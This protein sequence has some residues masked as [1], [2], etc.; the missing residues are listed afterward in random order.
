MEKLKRMTDVYDSI[1]ALRDFVN[2]TTDFRYRQMN[3]LDCGFRLC[4]AMDVLEDTDM[5]THGY[6]H[7]DLGRDNLTELYLCLYGLFQAMVVQQD[8]VASAYESLLKTKFDMG[9]DGPLKPVWDIRQTRISAFGHPTDREIRSK[10]KGK[11]NRYCQVVQATMGKGSFQLHIANPHAE[12]RED[13]DEFRDIDTLDMVKRQQEFTVDKLDRLVEKLKEEHEAFRQKFADKPLSEA[14]GKNL[15]YHLGKVC[16]CVDEGIEDPGKW[17]LGL[18]NLDMVS[19]ALENLESVLKERELGLDTYP[20]IEYLYKEL[21][22]P[23]GQLRVLFS[24]QVSGEELDR[25]IQDCGVFAWFVYVK[26]A[27]EKE[28]LMEL[29]RGIDQNWETGVM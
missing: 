13:K 22:H 24:Q 27:G 18:A 23:L 21:E 19:K 26:I 11:E 8:A 3:D 29:V 9:P 4:S 10:A 6:L 16:E 25:L 1:Q 14:F 15:P 12:E 17:Q 28:G 7:A 5:A 2:E 20:S